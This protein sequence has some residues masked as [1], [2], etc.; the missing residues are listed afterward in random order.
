M[1]KNRSDTISDGSTSTIKDTGYSK[2]LPPG[3]TDWNERDSRV[4]FSKLIRK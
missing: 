2:G 4:I 1:A 3:W